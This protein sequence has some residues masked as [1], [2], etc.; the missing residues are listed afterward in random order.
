MTATLD[1]RVA[2]VTGA[3]PRHRPRH[4]R[5]AC[6]PQA[7]AS[8]VADVGASIG[9]DG[10]DPGVARESLAKRLRQE[11]DRLHRKRRLARRRRSSSSSWRSKNFGGIDIVVNNAAI[12]R[13]AFVFRADPRD[14]DAVIRNNLSAPF[15]HHRRG[16]AGDA[17]AGQVAAAAARPTTGAASSTSSRRP[18]STAI[19]ARRPMPAPR[20]GLFGLTRVVA[21]DL[22]RAHDHRATPWRRSRAPA[23]PTSSSRPTRR[24]RP[25][26]SARCKIRR[27]PCRQPRDGLCSPAGQ[28]RHR[29]AAW[30]ARPRGLP[31]RPAAPGRARSTSGRR[32]RSA[33]THRQGSAPQFTD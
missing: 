2:I 4:R 29:P 16:D 32:R 18:G 10:G 20:P 33:P 17:R 13:D 5:V 28:G 6:T 15:Y 8:I 27:A 1:G 30:R 12:L 24:R 7:P 11:G 23:S 22:Q 9:G 31:V 25:T 26:R 3:R 14:W 21:M 19:S